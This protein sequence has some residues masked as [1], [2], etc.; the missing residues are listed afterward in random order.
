[1][2]VFKLQIIIYLLHL[3]LDIRI[4]TCYIFVYNLGTNPAGTILSPS[5]VLPSGPSC[6]QISR[7]LAALNL[8][9]CINT[10]ASCSEMSLDMILLPSGAKPN[11]DDFSTVMRFDSKK[12]YFIYITIVTM[13]ITLICFVV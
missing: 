12:L 1:M 2:F 13:K 7:Q 10:L 9:S 8:L 4:S 6:G 3:V 11:P 5:L